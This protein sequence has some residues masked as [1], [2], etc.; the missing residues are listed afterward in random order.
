[1]DAM[2]R[3]VFRHSVVGSGKGRR[4]HGVDTEASWKEQGGAG[5]AGLGSNGG[6]KRRQRSPYGRMPV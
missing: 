1:M 2:V 4:R 5:W 6:S 3:W